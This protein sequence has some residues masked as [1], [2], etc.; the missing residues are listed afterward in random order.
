MDYVILG[1]GPAGVT[2]AETIRGLDRNGRIT[3]IGGEPEPPY[4]RMAIPYLLHGSVGEHGT[5]LRQDDAHYAKLNIG[6]VSA[7]AGGVDT[8]ARKVFLSG[9]PTY[10]YDRLLIATGASPIIPRVPGANLPGVHACW[11]LPDA[12]E[13]LKL[14]DKGAPV[15][16]VGAGFIGSIVLEALHQRGCDITVV[17]IA[18]RMVARMMDEVAGGM[19]GRWCVEKGIKVKT[20][21]K[22]ERI[23]QAEAA[24]GAT[25]SVGLSDG[26]SVPARLV[27]LAAGVRSNVGFLVGTGIAVGTGIRVDETLQTS[28]PGVYA[29]G[30]CC[31]AIDLST[32]KPDML[33][34]QPVA[35][36]HGR[37]AGQNMAGRY[38]PHRGSLNMNV[39]DTMG[40]I[41]SSFGLW[42]G[43]P[44]GETAR[45]VD[46]ANFKYLKLEFLGNKLVG[47]QCVGLTDHVGMLRGLIQ[48]GVDLGIWKQRLMESPGRLREAYVATAQQATSAGPM[49]PRVKAP[50]ASAA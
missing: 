15:V 34:I 45:L 26:T 50:I 9:G 18:P 33:A 19:L 30:D 27:V 25:L 6:Y 17:E 1:A 44:G 24:N 36:E 3:L 14:A 8:K 23:S 16:L 7:K 22:V 46:D 49:G 12:R 32:G 42:Q 29:A 31:E 47:A 20:G 21:T 43:A 2:A 41:S 48:T 5:Y 39:L 13:I 38:T 37:I 28:V 35:V 11:T 40:L 10:T 4:S